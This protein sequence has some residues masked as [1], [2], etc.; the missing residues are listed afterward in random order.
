MNIKV[1]RIDDG[2]PPSVGYSIVRFMGYWLDSAIFYIG[3][4]L[5]LFD[6]KKQALHDK[7]A[8]TIVIRV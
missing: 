8:G 6:E 7:L 2:K 1:V 5:P 4:L 3:W